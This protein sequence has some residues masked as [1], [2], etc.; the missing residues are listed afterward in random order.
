[1]MSDEN[2]SSNCPSTQLIDARNKLSEEAKKQK[3][4]EVLNL[5]G[6]LDK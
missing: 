1:M 3:E 5:D 2:C 6:L 4:G